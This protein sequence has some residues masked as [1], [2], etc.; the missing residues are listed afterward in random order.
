MVG[1][2]SYN[3][4]YALAA[5][6]FVIGLLFFALLIWFVALLRGVRVSDARDPLIAG[7]ALVLTAIAIVV[8]FGEASG[9]L[10]SDTGSSVSNAPG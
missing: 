10:F 8:L 4:A 9:G 5:L 1:I 3:W 7:T 6:V 2:V